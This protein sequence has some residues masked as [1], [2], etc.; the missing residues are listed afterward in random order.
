MK[1]FLQGL[2]DFCF[3]AFCLHCGQRCEKSYHRLC[4]ECFQ[5]I[6]WIDERCCCP[7]CGHYVEGE[8]GGRCFACR[9]KP[10]YLQPHHSLLYPH[11]SILALFRDFKQSKHPEG[12]KTLASL[13]IIGLSHLP[14][15][16]PDVVVPFP[17]SR[18][19]TLF[20]RNQESFLLGKTMAK[21]L[22]LMRG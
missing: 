17:Q 13:M 15:P 2:L 16:S 4:Y 14:W 22:G 5:Q 7:I 20:F 19:E 3:P 9:E 18:I 6:E 8:R 10:C 11:P 21:M 1:A 12:A